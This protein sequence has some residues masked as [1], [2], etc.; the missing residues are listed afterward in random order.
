MDE[1]INTFVQYV[2]EQDFGRNYPDAIAPNS[3]YPSRR[4]E[5]SK[6]VDYMK[7]D[8]DYIT[9]IMSNPE[10]VYQLGNN[11][12]GKPATALNIL[13]ETVMGRELFDYSFKTY[14]HRWMFKHP[15]PV[16]FF[17][18][19]EDASAM[20]LDWYWRGWFYTTD[21]VDIGVKDVK[22]YYVTD[23]P[24]KE[25]KERPSRY[26]ID[27]NDTD[28]LYVVDEDSDDFEPSMKDK[29]TVENAPKLNEYL[30]DNFTP[31]QRQGMK[32]PKHFYAVS[33][34][35]PGGIPM[36]L[37]VEYTYKDGTKEKKKYPVQIWRKND[38]EVTK[39]LATDKELV[40]VQIDPDQETADVDLT[41]NSW[42]RE[43]TESKFEKFK[44]GVEN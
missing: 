33:F 29:S 41:N 24:T 20:D 15:T 34:N 21:N 26:N 27:P 16:D 12:Y 1:G 23:K 5:P 28:A 25:G 42:P 30:L 36:P 8:Q 6:I 38:K 14:A 31:Q 37:I 4:G 10:N 11:A 9:P 35:K 43:K 13:R 39:V 40:G 7:G 19:M 32:V 2:T 44:E 18:T 22:S 17:R 3:K